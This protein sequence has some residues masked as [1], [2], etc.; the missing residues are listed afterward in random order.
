ML[1]AL[2]LDTAVKLSTLGEEYHTEV[3]IRSSEGEKN[4][5]RATGNYQ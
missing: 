1:K 2:H 3:L 5:G 4:E